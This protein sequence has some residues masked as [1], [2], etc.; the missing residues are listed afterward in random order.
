MALFQGP[1]SLTHSRHGRAWACLLCKL[2]CAFSF[3][4]SGPDNSCANN[5]RRLHALLTRVR[6]SRMCYHRGEKRWKRGNEHE[7][8]GGGREMASERSAEDQV[9]ES[10]SE[11]F[12]LK[13][14]Q[15]IPIIPVHSLSP[16]LPL[17]LFLFLSP[18]LLSILSAPSHPVSSP[19]Y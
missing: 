8:G 4:R 10:H 5:N 16:S 3:A 11:T 13:Q 17:Y 18:S 2:I 9:R 7:G 19:F 6:A 12:R 14:C 15:H 1:R